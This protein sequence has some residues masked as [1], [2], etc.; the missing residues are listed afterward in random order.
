MSR[1]IQGWFRFFLEMLCIAILALIMATLFVDGWD[2]Q[3]KI[4]AA[5]QDARMHKMIERGF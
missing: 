1:L 5:N 2:K 4:D 3:E